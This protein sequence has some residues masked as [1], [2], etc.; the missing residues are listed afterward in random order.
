MNPI[1]HAIT[2]CSV[3]CIQLEP[4]DVDYDEQGIT[5][6]RELERSVHSGLYPPSITFATT[7]KE[8]LRR[9]GR[10]V[11]VCLDLF[12]AGKELTFMCKAYEEDQQ[13]LN[14][15]KNG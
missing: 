9:T 1:S 7:Y 15:S 4:K 10:P 12:G 11:W 8:E 3:H 14:G 13:Q 5:S 2:T 6:S